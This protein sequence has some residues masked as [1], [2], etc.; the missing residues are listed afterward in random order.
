MQSGPLVLGKKQK[1]DRDYGQELMWNGAVLG[2]TELTERMRCTDTWWNEVTDQLREGHLSKEN[3]QYL[4]GRPVS[5]C[6]LSPE[7]RDTR[8]R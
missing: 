2:V 4:H 3:W 8:H 5:G 7:E 6:M 1:A